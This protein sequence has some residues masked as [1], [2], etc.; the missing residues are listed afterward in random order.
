MRTTDNDLFHRTRCKQSHTN[1]QH[2]VLS[3]SSLSTG[4]LLLICSQAAWS[5]P[6]FTNGPSFNSDYG[7]GSSINLNVCGY[8]NG[9]NCDSQQSTTTSGGDGQA[10]D[11][12]TASLGYGTASATGTTNADA[13]AGTLGAYISST[14]QG[15]PGTGTGGGGED[16]SQFYNT[17]TLTGLAGLTPTINLDWSIHGAFTQQTFGDNAGNVKLTVNLYTS[18]STIYGVMPVQQVAGSYQGQTV[19]LSGTVNLSDAYNQLTGKTLT[20]GDSFI[21]EPTFYLYSSNPTYVSPI[22]TFTSDF[23]NTAGI[24]LSSSDPNVSIQ[25]AAVSTVPLPSSLWLGLTGLGSLLLF[26]RRRRQKEFQD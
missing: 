22:G 9:A 14:G 17:Y 26:A 19:D 1:C 11:T 12:N 15:T 24:S 23:L 16:I 25:S 4:V 6:L 2:N 8:V 7:A 3:R 20:V 13:A 21:L 5:F 10:T 18:P